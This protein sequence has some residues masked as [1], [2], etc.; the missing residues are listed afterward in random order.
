DGKYILAPISLVQQLFLQSG[1][2]S[3]LELSLSARSNPDEVKAQIQNLLGPAYIV[4]TRYEQ[5][6]TL[7]MVMKT[8]KWAVYVI[9]VLVLLIAS[10]NMIGALSLLVLEKQ[11]DI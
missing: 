11:K 1:N 3:S 2:Y 5:N 8:E 10:F 6:R 4:S 7:Y 9:L